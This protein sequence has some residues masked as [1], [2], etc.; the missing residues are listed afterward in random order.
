MQR[1]FFSGNSLDQAVMAAARQFQI[2]PEQLAYRV[3]DKKT[4]FLSGRRKVVIEVD[5]SE[6][7]LAEP[8]NVVLT[9][10]PAPQPVSNEMNE[11]PPIFV[12]TPAR[13]FAP[14]RFAEKREYSEQPRERRPAPANG[15]QG[16]RGRNRGSDMGSGGDRGKRPGDR[17]GGR[18]DTDSRG[19]GFRGDNRRPASGQ[20]GRQD[21][22]GRNHDEG[23][24]FGGGGGQ[25]NQNRQRENER[26]R[27]TIIRS[28]EHRWQNRD[29]LQADDDSEGVSREIIAF[30]RG[31]EMILDIVDID[32]EFSVTE[33]DPFK[34]E[35]AGE[36]HEILIAEDGQILKSIEHIL[37][38]LVRSAVGESLTCRVDCENFQA[39]HEEGIM[40]LARSV[41][42]EVKANKKAK[43]LQPMNPADRRLVHVA[44]MED[45]DVDT[46]SEGEGYIKRVKILPV[47]R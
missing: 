15:H 9:S 42:A 6:P 19:G 33:G 34:I 29:W 31:I 36:D 10:A 30:E 7:R 11:A 16:E 4:G 14:P 12:D 22:R 5:P 23:R 45:P 27:R 37:P 46:Q 8:S 21:N 3:R 44:L 17:N 25:G 26:S 40:A 39:S 1:Q 47:R 28:I 18:R 41:A 38:R 35:F 32:I 13:D 20:R 2:E 43:A 24:R